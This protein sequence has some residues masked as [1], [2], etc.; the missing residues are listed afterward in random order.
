MELRLDGPENA[1]VQLLFAHG[2][3]APMDSPSMNQ[4][5]QSLAANDLRI[6]R[7]EFSYMAARRTNG[8]RRPP[9]RADKLLDE[10][11]TAID[12][13]ETKMPLIIGGKSMGGRVASMIADECF[14]A[15]QISGL[16]CVGYPFHP[17]NKPENLR[18]KHLEHLQTP[19]LICQGV[20]DPFGTKEEVS[21]YS[22]SENVQI[23]WFEDGDHDL[24]PRKKNTGLSMADQMN[25]LG[26]VVG[27][28]CKSIN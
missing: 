18:T 9:P 23:A 25:H 26:T 13:I 5:T 2:A 22:L 19:A 14:S 21:R 24:K 16:L 15:G 3:G 20:R 8:N 12:Q 1:A 11:R 6:V 4:I 27:N 28:W 17:P 10:Y 7:F